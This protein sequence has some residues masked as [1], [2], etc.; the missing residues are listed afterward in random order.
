[1]GASFRRVHALRAVFPCAP[2]A[3]RERDA[4]ARSEKRRS[5]ENRGKQR[6]EKGRKGDACVSNNDVFR[7]SAPYTAWRSMPVLT[8]AQGAGGREGRRETG[9]EKEAGGGRTTVV[10]GER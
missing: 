6:R 10:A 8:P 3:R 9:E 1:M 2:E 4:D 7:C 5:R